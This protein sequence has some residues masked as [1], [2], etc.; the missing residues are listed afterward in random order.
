MKNTILILI[1]LLFLTG[2]SEGKEATEGKEASSLQEEKMSSISEPS[3]PTLPVATNPD[4]I[5]GDFIPSGETVSLKLHSLTAANRQHIHDAGV[6]N[7]DMSL[8]EATMTTWGGQEMFLKGAYDGGGD[9]DP[10]WDISQEE[11][12]KDGMD[13]FVLDREIASGR[14]RNHTTYLQAVERSKHMKDANAAMEAT[15]WASSPRLIISAL[16]MVLLLCVYFIRPKETEYVE[17]P[18]PQEKAHREKEKQ[19]QEQQEQSRKKNEEKELDD[20][21]VK[22]EQGDPEAQFNLGMKYDEGQEVIQDYKEAVK[23]YRKS[24]EQEYSNA[25]Y[26][27]GNKYYHGKGVV[28]DYVMAHMYWNIAAVSGDKDAIKNRGIVEQ[29]MTPS[30]LEKAQDLAREWMR[31]H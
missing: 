31:T 29:K 3:I 9:Y 12:D 26:N 28:Q 23:W 1:S 18:G 14:I 25:Q 19:E 2:A 17:E 5:A 21:R 11:Y 20:C 10:N 30:Q 7:R 13:Y 6:A 22:A 24:A 27:L 4:D 15:N 8:W 16:F